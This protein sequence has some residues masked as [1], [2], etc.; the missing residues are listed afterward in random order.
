MAGVVFREHGETRSE[1]LIF[2]GMHCTLATSGNMRF[3]FDGRRFISRTCEKQG[4]K[5]LNKSDRAWGGERGG[6]TGLDPSFLVAY[7]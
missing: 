6:E 5:M 4:P 3:V 7:F 2:D 1:R